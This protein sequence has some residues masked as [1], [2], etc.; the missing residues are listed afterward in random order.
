MEKKKY[1]QEVQGHVNEIF[2][3][4]KYNDIGQLRTYVD[5]KG[6]KWFCHVD[7][8]DILGISDPHVSMR[9]LTGPGICSAPVK[10]QRTKSNGT[11]VTKTKLMDFINEGNLFRLIT[12]SRKPE[13]KAFTNWVCD[14]VLPILN[15]KKGFHIMD[16][17][18]KED[19]IEELQKQI[20]NQEDKINLLETKIK[21]IARGIEELENIINTSYMNINDYSKHRKLV[22]NSAMEKY[23]G[24]MASEASEEWNAPVFSEQHEK[25]GNVNIY[26]VDVLKYVFDRFY[27]YADII[28][29]DED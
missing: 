2:E 29:G 10:V 15:S 16:N 7:V 4:F 13:A 6:T 8:C 28:Y 22:V 20:A 12:C 18:P 3:I 14:V 19:V 21:K 9:R 1:S 27:K 11:T 25:R 26:R 17:K 23:L 24:E 5:G